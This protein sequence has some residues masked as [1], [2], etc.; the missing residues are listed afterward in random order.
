M[1]VGGFL[2]DELPG[3]L[4]FFSGVFSGQVEEPLIGVG[5]GEEVISIAEG[6]ESE[7][8]IFHQAVNGFDVGLKSMLAGG[9]G[10]MDLAGDGF[11]SSSKGGGIFGL[12]G[13]DE[14]G[15][16][17][18]LPGGLG[19]FKAAGFEMFQDALREQVGISPTFADRR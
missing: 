10:A 5:F 12:P 14:F 16:V 6:F 7:E 9:N 19:E 17:V 8:L 15:A 3:G 18:G 4:I 1:G 11:N 2:A 13:A